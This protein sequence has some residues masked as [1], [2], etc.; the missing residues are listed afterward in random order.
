MSRLV[1][2]TRTSRAIQR[3]PYDAD[4]E[5]VLLGA[6]LS[7][8]PAA[9]LVATQTTS[10]DFYDPYHQ[11]V[12]EAIV[13]LW[14][15]GQP[16]EIATVASDMARR[17]GVP[18][19]ELAKK[20]LWPLRQ[21]CAVPTNAAVYLQHVQE[22]TRRRSALVLASEL[23]RIAHEGGSLDEQLQTV[24]L[25]IE[26]IATNG[27]AVV[28]DRLIPAGRFVGSADLENRAL[29]GRGGDVLHA[30]GEPTFVVARTGLGKSTYAQNYVLRRI[31]IWTDSLLGLPVAPLPMDRSILYIAADRPKQVKASLRR[32]VS[33]ADLPLLD[34]AVDVWRGPPPFL[35]NQDPLRFAAWIR[36]LEVASG[37][38]YD[39]IILDSLKDVANE[40]AKDEGGSAV[41]IALSRLVADD[42]NVL[43][44][45]HERKAE[46]VAK[47][48]P[49]SID[50]IYGSQFLAAC[51][52][53]VVY[54]FGEPGAHVFSLHHLKQSAD[55]VGPLTVRHDHSS[56]RLEIQDQV[57]LLAAL[58]FRP[59][60]MTAK[61]ACVPLFADENP[62]ANTIEKARR[63][64]DKLVEAGVAHCRGGL[65]GNP[66]CYFP[67][68]TRYAE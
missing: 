47:K 61:D 52:G 20:Q 67:S 42:R 30:A 39:E 62:S 25:G 14:D 34:E 50:D 56:G 13:T 12:R 18:D 37:R 21:A 58:R 33:D 15:S 16:I 53:N 66:N 5:A 40:L 51:A 8:R 64:L 28:E 1:T 46:R 9:E 49:G 3:I 41:A 10:A 31:N 17:N 65:P 26:Q 7:T 63:R 38:I 36:A 11:R 43:V 59:R 22:W 68:E 6:A 60:G 19:I 35:L 23:T 27:R 24:R 4:D 48:A 45:H 32:M 55:E 57:D 44:L 54:L 2:K 29:H